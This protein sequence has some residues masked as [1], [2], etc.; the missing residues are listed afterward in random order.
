M[1]TYS[2]LA[3]Q[4]DNGLLQHKAMEPI[5]LKHPYLTLQDAYQIRNAGILLR[6]GRGE[7]VV[8]YKM[9]LT[10]LAKQKQM[11]ISAPIFGVLTDAMQIQNEQTISLKNFIQPKVEPEIAFILGEDL[12]GHVSLEQAL[13]ACSGVCAALDVIDSRYIDFK[14]TLIDVVAD[15][16]SAGGYVLG[17]IY[18]PSGFDLANL[19]MDLIVNDVIVE[20]GNSNTI[21]GNPINSLIML[22]QL[23]AEQGSYLKAGEIV[24]S[25]ASMSAITLKPDLYVMN[26]TEKLGCAAVKGEGQSRLLA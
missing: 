17:P 3:A 9:G 1:D 24:L 6:E 2:F 21:L 26:K 23:L 7:K 11:H 20:K 5:V 10:S 14:F 19:S 15:N 4:L 18:N 8:G 13:A 25:G 12:R 16:T 22:V